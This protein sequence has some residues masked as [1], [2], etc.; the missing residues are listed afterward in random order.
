M[1]KPK[2]SAFNIIQLVITVAAVMFG[3]YGFIRSSDAP[4]ANSVIAGVPDGCGPLDGGSGCSPLEIPEDTP[5]PRPRPKPPVDEPTTPEVFNPDDK[6]DGSMKGIVKFTDGRGVE[7]MRITAI[8]TEVNVSAPNWDANDLDKT[9]ADYDRYFRALKRNTRVVFSDS[10]GHFDIE[11]LDETHSY[12]VTASSADVGTAEQVSKSGGNLTFEFEVPVVV[13][14]VVICDGKLPAQWWVTSNVDNGQGWFE[15]VHSASFSDAEGKFRIRAK[16][17]KVQLIVTAQ[18]WIQDGQ[19]VFDVKA[20]GAT[21]ELKL[22]KAAVLSGTV[23]SKEGGVLQSVTIMMNSGVTENAGGEREDSDGGGFR[24]MEYTL[25]SSAWSGEVWG[26]NMLYGYTDATGKY[27]IEG[28]RPGT[29]T[30][31]ATMGS[32]SESREVTVAS[33]ENYADF[34]L[35]SGCRVKVVGRNTKGDVV[36]P[37]YAWFVGADQNYAQGVQLPMVKAGELEYIG[38]PE[39]TFTMTVQANNYPNIVQEV[40]IG[41][42]SNTFDVQFQEPATLKGKIASINGRVPANLYVRMTPAALARDKEKSEGE[43]YGNNGQY[44]AVEATG[45]YICQNLQPGEYQLSVE[46]NQYDTLHQQDIVVSAG[47]QTLDLT[48]D[49]RSTITVIVDVAPELKN[50]EGISI[51]ISKTNSEGGYVSRYGTL[52][53]DNKCE[54]AFLPDGEYYVYAYAQDGTQSYVT[55]TIGRGS[56]TV[57]LSLGPPNCVKITEVVDGSQGAEAGVKVGDLVIEYNG[58]VIT[59]MNDLVK[60]VQATKDGD[61][62]SLV[63]VRN[64]SSMIFRLNGGRIGINGDNYRR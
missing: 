52:D 20:E 63:V 50:K 51:S 57:N 7:G 14:G 16:A 48:I 36:T 49:E 62:V 2:F 8:S 59:N 24:I 55:A 31:T 5:K 33:G 26:G 40:R 38:M 25:K 46:F 3:V 27:R 6:G 12:R 22:A 18:G 42:G 23:T 53:K 21:V 60:E 10:T 1:L 15:Y 56:N 39:G 45:N 17:G 34:S 61:N 54:F 13:E 29:Y 37:Q 9:H 41:R 64:G 58:I 43:M 47:E 19:T 35:D 28:I 4:P 30:V 44:F 32:F 11:G